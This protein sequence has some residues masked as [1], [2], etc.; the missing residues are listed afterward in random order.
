LITTT[1]QNRT[2]VA[3]AG[4]D[5]SAHVGESVQLDGSG[6]ADADGDALTYAWALNTR[7]AN[8][9]ATLQG[10]DTASPALSI[11]KAGTYVAQLIVSD[12]QATSAPD[13]VAIST[14]NSAPVASISA[15]STV[16]WGSTVT[17]DGTASS[18]L[19]G[20]A[21]GFNWSMLSR[22][23]GSDAALD[24]P[25]AMTSAFTADKPGV[26]VTQLVVNDGQANSEPA[27]ATVTATN[28]APVANADSASTSIG[29]AVDINVLAN[30]T[31]A[32]GNSLSIASVTQPAHGTASIN[33]TVVRYTPTAGFSGADAFAY[34]ATR[35]HCRSR[36]LPIPTPA[37]TS[38]AT[39]SCCARPRP[40]LRMV[41]QAARN[42]C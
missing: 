35:S 6:S 40:Q 33:G 15:P 39:R 28:N 29:S 5:Q 11:D 16:R 4:A 32:D 37:T 25:S 12:G 17:L 19:D 38:P 34:T 42:S 21:I 26:Y 41:A 1:Q 31:D 8:S 18:D 7:P 13:T 22:P 23:D 10:A 27:S 30:D 20:D 9:A 24:G 36:A 2:P 3:N 14:L